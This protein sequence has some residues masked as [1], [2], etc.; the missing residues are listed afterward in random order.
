[1]DFVKVLDFGLVK[2]SGRG[3]GDAALTAQHLAIGTPAYMSPEQALGRS[4]D[5]RSD[6]YAVGC[7]AYWL[8]TGLPV[9]EGDSKM[10]VAVQHVSAPPV[11]MSERTE[12]PIP[13]PLEQVVLS[14]LAKDPSERPASASALADA[15]AACDARAEWS[16]PHAHAWW[17]RHLPAV[18]P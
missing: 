7:V 17:D 9:F 10:A 5:A 18:S 1:V 13:A 16:G 6:L 11:P 12:L 14:C 15:L 8:L 2:A 3:D 4:Q